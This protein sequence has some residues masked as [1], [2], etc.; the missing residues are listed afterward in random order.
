[1]DH[2]VFFEPNNYAGVVGNTVIVD[3]IHQRLEKSEFEIVEERNLE[4]TSLKLSKS[5][6]RVV[7]TA[8]NG[9]LKIFDLEKKFWIDCSSICAEG[10]ICSDIKR[11]HFATGG[12]SGTVRGYARRRTVRLVNPAF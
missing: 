7:L 1:M 10:V 2:L 12:A 4:V 3:S 11:N 8:W 9:I 6:N 5:W